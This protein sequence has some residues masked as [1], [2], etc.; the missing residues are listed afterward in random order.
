MYISA[1]ETFTFKYYDTG[2]NRHYNRQDLSLFFSTR[3]PSNARTVQI[4]MR[5]T[6][7]PHSRSLEFVNYLHHE[8]MASR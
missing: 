4:Y 7:P 1:I 8:P 6:V 3:C 2:Y 5:Q